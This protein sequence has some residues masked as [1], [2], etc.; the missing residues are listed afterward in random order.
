[1][2]VIQHSLD[3][4]EE[5]FV[6]SCH[7]LLLTSDPWLV[8]PVVV[9]PVLVSQQQPPSPSPLDDE[10]SWFFDEPS[11]NLLSSEA[12]MTTN[13]TASSPPLLSSSSERELRVERQLYCGL[14]HSLWWDYPSPLPSSIDDETQD[15]S[16]TKSCLVSRV[17]SC[18]RHLLCCAALS[19]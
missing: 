10:F 12:F 7:A 8:A 17:R 3:L 11:D 1:M 18:L 6:K 19:L 15:I 14:Q 4:F 5:I 13:V 2:K 16:T 9:S